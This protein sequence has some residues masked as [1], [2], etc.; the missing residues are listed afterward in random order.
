M[1]QF[2]FSNDQNFSLIHNI[3][4]PNMNMQEATDGYVHVQ[5]KMLIVY[6]IMDMCCCNFRDTKIL[7]NNKGK[8]IFKINIT[9]NT[10]LTSVKL[11]YLD[12]SVPVKL[13]EFLSRMFLF[14]KQ[15]KKNVS[16]FGTV[17][18]QGN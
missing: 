8:H 9:G 15:Q 18:S 1:T 5:K 2:C 11:N 10:I 6:K 17:T 7:P 4:D 13:P 12:G 14:Y 16:S 3:H